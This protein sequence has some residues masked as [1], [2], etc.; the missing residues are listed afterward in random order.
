MSV[1]NRML[2]DID[3]RR[4]S[5]GFDARPNL[6]IRS[7]APGA[8]R[9]RRL[10]LSQRKRGGKLTA[11]LLVIV[12]A[13][14]A[15]FVWREWQMRT[16]PAVPA[17]LTVAMSQPSTTTAATTPLVP[18]PPP[19]VTTP[20]VVEPVVAASLV[21]AP[22]L[23]A[24][25]VAVVQPA[26]PNVTKATLPTAETLKLSMKL[27]A[28]V[29]DAPPVMTA[30]KN[31]PPVVTAVPAPAP[32]PATITT[33]PNSTPSSTPLRQVA[34]DETVRVARGLW[35]EGSRSAA[36]E[37][38]REALASA[39]AARNT[40]AMAPLVRELARLQVADNHA[41]TGLDLL[42]RLENLLIDDADAWA[43]RGNAE[44][45]LALHNEAAESYL[46]ALRLRPT[47]G[48]WMIGAAISLAASGRQDDARV[49]VERARERGAVTPTIAAYLQQLGI[50]ARQ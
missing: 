19:V 29:A 27:S 47:E 9:S 25:T 26:S 10:P 40:R 32:A 17:P 21:S 24:A 50:A 3:R 37:T 28:L 42:K 4:S 23:A 33:T 48:K 41:Q 15:L 46:A 44:Q 1:V 18:L 49:W 13:M 45:R 14:V 2:Q 6:D 22:A 36:M 5:A 31:K 39:E 8:E 34:A 11:I 7:V 16:V 35:N 20:A 30:V 12:G 38:L 43:L